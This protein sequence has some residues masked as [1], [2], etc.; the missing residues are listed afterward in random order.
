VLFPEK[1]KYSRCSL[2]TITCPANRGSEFNNACKI[3]YMAVN[4]LH[5]CLWSGLA[6]GGSQP[7]F[8]L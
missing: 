6:S 4:W 3:D 5:G 8:T 1:S 2:N 7:A